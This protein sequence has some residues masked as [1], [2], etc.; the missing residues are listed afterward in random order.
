MPFVWDGGWI[1]PTADA[2]FLF[3]FNTVGTRV[4]AVKMVVNEANVDEE[5]RKSSNHRQESRLKILH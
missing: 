1:A 2:S 4:G 5:D 3:R